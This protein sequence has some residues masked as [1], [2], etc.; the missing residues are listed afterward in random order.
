MPWNEADRQANREHFR[1]KL[2]AIKERNA[3]LKAIEQGPFD[4]VL[5]DTR[6]RDAFKFGHIPGAWCAP[7][8][9]LNEIMPRLP[10]DREIVTYCWGHD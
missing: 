3:V 6:P 5:L 7:F 1:R 4:F 8:A 9:D 2:E 10:K